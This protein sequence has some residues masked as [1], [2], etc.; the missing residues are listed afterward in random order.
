MDIGRDLFRGVLAYKPDLAVTECGS[1][2]MQIEHGTHVRTLHPAEILTR[3][4]KPRARK[5]TENKLVRESRRA[6]YLTPR[7]TRVSAGNCALLRLGG[8]RLQACN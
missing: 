3:R 5:R 1:C 2:Q 6:A 7:T 4:I 8:A